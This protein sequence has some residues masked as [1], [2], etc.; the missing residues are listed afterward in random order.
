M[1]NEIIKEDLREVTTE[2]LQKKLEYVEYVPPV[3]E[4]FEEE[5]GE[6]DEDDEDDDASIQ[7]ED[8]SNE[9]FEMEYVSN[10]VGFV[11]GEGREHEEDSPI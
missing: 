7:I 1:I 11:G 8:D 6:F 9:R 4:E 2:D 10:G 3:E 5:E